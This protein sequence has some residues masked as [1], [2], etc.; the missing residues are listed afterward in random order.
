[1]ADYAAVSAT[2][3]AIAT[4]GVIDPTE[5]RNAVRALLLILRERAPGR[6]V[7]MRVPPYGAIQCVAGPRHTRGTPPNVVETDPLTFVRLATGSLAW[8]EAVREGRVTASG[9][10]ADLSA[11]L[12]VWPAQPDHSDVD[13]R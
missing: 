1:M 11:Y 4:G 6:S 3:E 8:A 7:E 5:L 2:V 9:V 10:R 13:D 12:P